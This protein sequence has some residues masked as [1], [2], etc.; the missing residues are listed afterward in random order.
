MNNK[1][2]V[3]FYCRELTGSSFSGDLPTELGQLPALR[4][5]EVS[6]NSFTGDIGELQ[7]MLCA[8]DARTSASILPGNSFTGIV[9]DQCMYT[10]G[11]VPS[12]S[13]TASPTSSPVSPAASMY[14]SMRDFASAVVLVLCMTLW[15]V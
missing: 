3:N 11:I 1:C 14:G 6:G 9:T 15:Q 12:T 5:L 2:Y 4:F 8:I 7:D 13:F 10:Q